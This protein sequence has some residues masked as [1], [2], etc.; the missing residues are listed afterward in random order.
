MIN[1]RLVRL[2]PYELSWLWGS[3]IV[4]TKK[5]TTAV[6]PQQL[7]VRVGY[8]SNQKLLHHYQH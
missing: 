1:I 3:Q 5:S 7:K 6:D 4:V 8:L 2:S